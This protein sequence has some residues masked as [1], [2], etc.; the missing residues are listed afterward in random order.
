MIEIE[1]KDFSVA[2]K[3]MRMDNAFEDEAMCNQP[4]KR[5]FFLYEHMHHF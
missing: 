4:Q 1:Q 5:T 3:K 2:S